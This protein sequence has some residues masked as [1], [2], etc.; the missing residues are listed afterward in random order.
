R[1]LKSL[2]VDIVKIDGSFVNDLV[3]DEHSRL[4]VRT[5]LGLAAGFGLT[6]VAES[7]DSAATADL[8]IAEGVTYLQGYYFGEPRLFRAPG[9]IEPAAGRPAAEPTVKASGA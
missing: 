6:T 1:H 3:R 5:L 7:I 8:L 2:P 9:R 4:F